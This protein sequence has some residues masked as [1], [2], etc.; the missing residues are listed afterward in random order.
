MQVQERTAGPTE[1]TRTIQRL[2]APSRSEQL[3]SARVE[4]GPVGVIL[5]CAG[6]SLCPSR[7]GSYSDLF[8]ARRKM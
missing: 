3:F 7:G 6:R 4:I 2:N 1:A 8:L 5:K